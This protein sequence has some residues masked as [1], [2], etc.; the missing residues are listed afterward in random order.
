ME[1]NLAKRPGYGPRCSYCRS[2][3]GA[4]LT[5][6]PRCQLALHAECW[7]ELEAC[8]TIGCSATAAATLDPSIGGPGQVTC[9]ACQSPTGGDDAL[10]NCR[11]CGLALHHGCWRDL[12]LCPTPGCGLSGEEAVGR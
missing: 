1:L 7:G 4:A 8:P 5:P 6:C 11:A 10:V 12:A 3:D 2:D 9:A